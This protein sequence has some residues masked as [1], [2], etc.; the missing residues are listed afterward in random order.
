[1]LPGPS[2]VRVKLGTAPPRHDTAGTG[3][4]AAIRRDPPESAYGSNL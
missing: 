2:L 4:Y 1:M 3:A